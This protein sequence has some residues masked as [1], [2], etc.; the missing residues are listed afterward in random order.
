MPLYCS[1]EAYVGEKL[2]NTISSVV[3]LRALLHT[4]SASARTYDK[5]GLAVIGPAGYGSYSSL[6]LRPANVIRPDH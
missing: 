1:I 5:A 2:T 3:I 6:S 4:E